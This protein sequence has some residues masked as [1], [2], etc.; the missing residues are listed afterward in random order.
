MKKNLS[1]LLL[2]VVTLVLLTLPLILP[3][4]QPGFFPTHDGEWAVVRLSDMYR[5]IR[6]G[7]IPPRFSGN[8]NFG[9]GYPL[10]QYAYP[11]PYYL[12]LIFYLMNFGL[13]GSIKLLFAI[14][15]PLSAI[16][17]YFASYGI[18]RSR[19]GSY[20]SAILYAYLPYRM[21]DLYSRGSLGESLASVLFPLILLAV[22]RLKNKQSPLWI[23]VLSFSFAGLV[24]THNIMAVLFSLIIG[25]YLL[26]LFLI[27][28]R[29]TLIPIGIS[30]LFGLGISAFFWLPAILEKQYILLSK[31]PIADRDLYYIPLRELLYSPFGYGVPTDAD[32]F[33]YQIGPIHLIL[34]VTVIVLIIKQIREKKRTHREALV[35]LCTIGAFILLLFPFSSLVWENTP[36]LKEINYPFT[37]LLPIGFLVT[38]VIGYLDPKNM[39]SKVLL[40]ALVFIAMVQV[41]QYA[42]PSEHVDRDEGFYFTNDATTTSS[43]EL[44]PLWV[45]TFPQSRASDKVVIASG[46]GTV[47][48]T[49]NRS[50]RLTFQASL[51]EDSLIRVN[52][53]YYPEWQ[54]YEGSTVLPFTYDNDYGVMEARLPAGEHMVQLRFGNTPVRI[55][56]NAV[57]ILSAAGLIGYMIFMRKQEGRKK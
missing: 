1:S 19:L 18:F 14:S 44:M 54:W 12:G 13:V 40:G 6:D 53:I 50:H 16:F 32:R 49:E 47:T 10:F 43:R 3:Y 57:S 36:L 51:Q 46:S 8:L 11:M 42:R 30:L 37:L 45:K 28:E 41:F 52:T 9:Y 33:T 25:A 7:Q 23:A 24:L 48:V 22:I 21:V 31:I 5:E 4:L 17:M 20:V 27:K 26:Y 34:L 2:P 39:A 35:F 38:L 15:V 56:A 55:A 29:K